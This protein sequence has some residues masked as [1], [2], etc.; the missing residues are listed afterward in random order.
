MIEVHNDGVGHYHY[1]P[2]KFYGKDVR[3]KKV[4]MTIPPLLRKY[5]R[6][7][8]V[9]FIRKPLTTEYLCHSQPCERGV[10]TTTE[11]TTSAKMTYELHLGQALMAERCRQELLDVRRKRLFKE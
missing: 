3:N 1:M 2:A 4:R 8:I 11:A 5:S 6:A 9:D 7:E 10:K